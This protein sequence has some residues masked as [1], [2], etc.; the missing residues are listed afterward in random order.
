MYTLIQVIYVIA[1]S[2]KLQTCWNFKN[3][4]ERIPTFLDSLLKLQY[5]EIGLE[6][7]TSHQ[8][9]LMSKF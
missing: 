6:Q 4:T 8:P 7:P 5:V 2:L 9:I 1:T 3:E